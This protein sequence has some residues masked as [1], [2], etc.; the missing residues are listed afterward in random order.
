MDVRQVQADLVSALNNLDLNK[1][2][3]KRMSSGKII[4]VPKFGLSRAEDK[5]IEHGPNVWLATPI[6]P[7]DPRLVVFA[8]SGRPLTAKDLR[9]QTRARGSTL[10]QVR[11]ALVSQIAKLN[12][13]E[14]SGCQTDD[15]YIWAIPIKLT[16][17]ECIPCHRG[18][19]V[20]D[21]VAISAYLRDRGSRSDGP[22][23]SLY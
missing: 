22:H 15:F 17:P 21:T 20:G 19:K 7:R 4:V 16:K 12:R 1:G 11:K 23:I 2:E 9:A 10:D 5:L 14:E 8:N 3:P 13:G 18:M 6:L